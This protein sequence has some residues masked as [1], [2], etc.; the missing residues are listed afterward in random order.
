[1]LRNWYETIV[2]EGGLIYGFLDSG[3]ES[4]H[5]FYK[6]LGAMAKSI[7]LVYCCEQK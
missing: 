3:F 5:A 1:M 4:E 6:A 7:I 2:T